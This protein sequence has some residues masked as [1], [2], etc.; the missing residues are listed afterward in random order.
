MML[1]SE[2]F[3][4][5]VCFF[6]AKQTILNEILVFCVNKNFSGKN[7]LNISTEPTESTKQYLQ[8][9]GIRVVYGNFFVRI[10]FCGDATGKIQLKND[11]SV[12]LRYIR[13][14]M[15]ASPSTNKLKMKTF[16]CHWTDRYENSTATSFVTRIDPLLSVCQRWSVIFESSFILI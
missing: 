6:F 14:L 4:W 15:P 12:D 10:S 8:V 16:Q 11:L 3:V 9:N 5:T 13:I 2:V 7:Q 1:L